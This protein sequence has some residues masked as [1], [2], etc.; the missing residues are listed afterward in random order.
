MQFEI[1]QLIENKK[2]IEDERLM[3]LQKK[4]DAQNF[5]RKQFEEFERKKTEEK[6]EKKQYNED[7]LRQMEA[8]NQRDVFKGRNFRNVSLSKF[9]YNKWLS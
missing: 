2:R 8:N 1:A 5:F 6:L 7:Y 3:R 4:Q 9:K